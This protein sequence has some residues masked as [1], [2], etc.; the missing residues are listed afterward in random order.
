MYHLY[1][2][3]IMSVWYNSPYLYFAMFVLRH[4]PCF[5][6]TLSCTMA[7]LATFD[8]QF[9]TAVTAT[10]IIFAPLGCSFVRCFPSAFSCLH[11]AWGLGI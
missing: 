3:V 4:V 8:N 10:A 1:V 7:I 2:F 6:F 9:N 11:L 5:I